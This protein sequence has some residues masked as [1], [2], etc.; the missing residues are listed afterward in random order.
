[1]IRHHKKLS[2]KKNN[3]IGMHYSLHIQKKDIREKKLDI[4]SFK[5]ELS[6]YLFYRDEMA[7]YYDTS[8]EC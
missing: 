1:M 3:K 4:L 5:T 2:K 8:Y 7:E 6:D